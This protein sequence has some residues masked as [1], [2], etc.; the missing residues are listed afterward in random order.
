MYVNAK[1]VSGKI[2]F[3]E[4]AERPAAAGMSPS[5]LGPYVNMMDIAMMSCMQIYLPLGGHLARGREKER[6]EREGK[7][8]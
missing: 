2:S 5:A 8:G 7:G 3:N 4:L 1:H 6:G